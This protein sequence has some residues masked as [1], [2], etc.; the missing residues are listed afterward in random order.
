MIVIVL[1]LVEPGFMNQRGAERLKFAV[2]AG[3]TVSETL[4]ECTVVRLWYPLIVR[5]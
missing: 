5:P 2:P 1:V 3:F 4:V